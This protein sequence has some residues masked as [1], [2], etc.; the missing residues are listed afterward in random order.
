[1]VKVWLVGRDLLAKPM[2]SVSGLCHIRPQCDSA[3]RVQ[4]QIRTDDLTQVLREEVEPQVS[5]LA[6]YKAFDLRKPGWIKVK[7]EPALD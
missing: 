4:R 7:M 2:P 6:A 3:R 5:A 1:M